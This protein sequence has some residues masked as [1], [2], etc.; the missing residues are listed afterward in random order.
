MHPSSGETE[1]IK[2]NAL[3]AGRMRLWPAV[4]ICVGHLALLW[5]ALASPTIIM[6]AVGIVGAPVLATLLLIIWWMTASRSP[7]RIRL[8][9]LMLYLAI[10]AWIVLSQ[11]HDGIRM[12]IVALPALNFGLVAALVATYRVPRIQM[13]MAIVVLLVGA[14][15]FPLFRITDVNSNLSPVLGWRWTPT[16]EE[17]LASTTTAHKPGARA[18]V[19]AQAAPEDWP[20]FRGANRDGVAKGVEFALNW[21]ENP[22]KELWRRRVGLG[23]SSFAAVG[24]YLFTQEQRFDDEAVVCY[25]AA[26]GDEIWLTAVKARFEDSTGSGPRATPT[27][28]GG[29]IYAQ[30]ATGI[31]HCLDAATGAPL[32]QKDIGEDTGAGLPT[33]GFASSPLVTDKHVII[34]SGG[35]EGKSVA[36]YDKLTGN[37]AW[38]AGGG[39]HGYASA[40]QFSID[41]AAQILMASSLG[42]QSFAPET[43]SLMWEHRWPVSTNPRVVQPLLFDSNGVLLGTAEGKGTRLLEVSKTNDT[44]AVQEKWTT[45]SFRPYFNDFVFHNGYC[46][47]FDGNMLACMDARTG[48]RK[49]K[50]DRYGGQLLLV[51]DLEVLV[52]LTEK[53]K[54]ALV[55]A[56]P[57]SFEEIAVVDALA[58]KTW[59][60]PIVAHGRLIVRNAEEA[61]CFELPK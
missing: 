30:G 18:E 23:F 33:W 56:T 45:K 34:F 53:G 21:Q 12:L 42:I 32:W 50:G 39:T 40:Q 19:P 57:E 38:H 5:V 11:P 47:G 52:V 61:V 7:W 24:D 31:L 27:F 54:I 14:V 9:G 1:E 49:W 51:E 59:N 48:D 35:P 58:G 41:G 8:A 28:E 29:K 37:R 26:T 4:A 46:Y 3:S 6:N 55:K 16:S 25:G 13:A 44:W 20:G 22:P 43:G 15:A 60:H 17:L 10:I 36:A 2:A